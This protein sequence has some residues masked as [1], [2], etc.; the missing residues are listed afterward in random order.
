[1]GEV[2]QRIEWMTPERRGNRIHQKSYLQGGKRYQGGEK[3][4]E[5]ELEPGVQDG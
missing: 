4:R 3:E 1:M 5:E 2:N